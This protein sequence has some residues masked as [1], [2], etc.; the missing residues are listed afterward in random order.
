MEAAGANIEQT[1]TNLAS[2][3][4]NQH[5]SLVILL[6]ASKYAMR[7]RFLDLIFGNFL[8]SILMTWLTAFFVF[9]N[10]RV[11]TYWTVILI[12]SNLV[13][14]KVF[15]VGAEGFDIENRN[16]HPSCMNKTYEEILTNFDGD[17]ESLRRAMFN[18]VNTNFTSSAL[19]GTQ[20]AS[21]GYDLGECGI[22][23]EDATNEVQ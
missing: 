19:A 2:R 23:P 16:I 5:L 7:S 4:N 20:L 17:K 13:L 8:G 21:Y 15:G 12:V 9:R 18:A 3:I 6:F 11:A 14:E 22:Y 1:V 10:V